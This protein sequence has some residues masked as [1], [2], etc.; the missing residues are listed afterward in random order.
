FFA[1]GATRI[2]GEYYMSED[3][4]STVATAD[5]VAGVAVGDVVDTGINGWGIGLVQAIDNAAMELYIGY[6]HFEVDQFDINGVANAVSFED[7]DVVITGA[8][9]KF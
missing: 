5:A 7:F 1:L 3:R 6:R 8:R 2:Y 9:I 4:T